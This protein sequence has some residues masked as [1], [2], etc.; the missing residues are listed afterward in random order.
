MEISLTRF[1]IGFQFRLT[2][3]LG[4]GAFITWLRPPKAGIDIPFFLAA[5][6]L[7]IGFSFAGALLSVER[8]INHAGNSKT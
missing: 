2:I 6:G 1:M 5:V 7:A 4:P 8:S 3:C